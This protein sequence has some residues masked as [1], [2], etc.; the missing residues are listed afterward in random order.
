MSLLVLLIPF[1]TCLVL[2]IFFR[3]KVNIIEYLCTLASSFLLYSIFY[4]VSKSIVES[5]TEYL[6]SYVESI[7]HEDDWDEWIHKTCT[8]KVPSGRDS[9]GN[10]I[11]KTETYDCSYRQYHPDKWYAKPNIGSSFIIDKYE[12]DYWRKIWDTPEIFIDK[13]RRYYTIDGDAQR[14]DRSNEILKFWNIT[15]SH[16]YSNPIM[17]SDNIYSR[18]KVKNKTGLYEYPEIK[19]RDQKNILGIS[20]PS[21]I[22]KKWR[23]INSYY[24]YKHQIRIYLMFFHNKNADIAFD[25]INYWEGG[26]KN[27]FLIMIGLDGTA[28][29]QWA[30]CHSWSDKP[31]MDVN[32]E[33]YIS[34][35]IGK[36]I[37]LN[38]LADKVISELPNWKRK[39]F[40]DFEYID[41]EMSS[42]LYIWLI[43]SMVLLSIICAY[44]SVTN[45]LNLM[46]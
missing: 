42:T 45:K 15:E 5:D 27:E 20:V 41:Y 40:K 28:N 32:I 38:I 34:S 37:D 1:I 33:S 35:F 11:Y 25:Q 44:V 46:K 31:V 14:Y 2:F 22:D 13:K 24:G 4:F 21:S 7:Y 16:G 18:K 19:N 12:Y 3:S 23:Y 43:I 29:I 26:N 17:R 10:T 9:K 36:N 6:G 39:E 30:K 8:R